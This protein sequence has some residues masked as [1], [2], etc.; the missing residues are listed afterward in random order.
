MTAIMKIILLYIQIWGIPAGSE[1]NKSACNIGDPGSV[2]DWEDP[3]EKGM[4]THCIILAWATPWTEEP[5]GL[6]SIGSQK[7]QT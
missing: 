6:Q 7:S 4:A 5:G 3:L 1:G 2:P